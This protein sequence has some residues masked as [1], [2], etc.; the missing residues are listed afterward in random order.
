M[1]EKQPM[2]Q[3]MEGDEGAEVN[4]GCYVDFKKRIPKSLKIDKGLI[5]VKFSFFFTYAALGSYMPYLI[6]FLISIGLSATQAGFIIGLKTIVSLITGLAWGVIVDKTGKIKMIHLIVF[7]CYIFVVFS[8]PW[9]GALVSNPIEETDAQLANNLHNSS[10]L[11]NTTSFLNTTTTTTTMMPVKVTKA[12]NAIDTVKVNNVNEIFYVMTAILCLVAVFESP[13]QGI[14]DSLTIYILR[15]HKKKAN[16]GMQRAFGG[17]GLASGNLFAGLI[18]DIYDDPDM[19]AYTGIFYVFLVVSL[20]FMGV[21]LYV[22]R[23]R[24]M[25]LR[26]DDEILEEKIKLDDV[27]NVDENIE[28]KK[29]PDIFKPVLKIFSR[30][31]NV[32]FFTT[33]CIIGFAHSINYAILF[34]YMADDFQASKSVMGLSIF[35]AC[36]S[37]LLIFPISSKIISF[38]KGP[39]IAVLVGLFSYSL[40]YCLYSFAQNIWI[41]ICLQSLH[42]FGFGLFWS[43]AVEHTKRLSTEYTLTTMFMILNV[44]HTPVGNLVGNMIGGYLYEQHGGRTFFLGISILLGSWAFL[45]LFYNIFFNKEDMDLKHPE[46]EMDD[47]KEE[48]EKLQNGESNM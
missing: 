21:I 32:L 43:A 35:I 11:M 14:L 34:L 6:V 47:C 19:S 48:L 20:S 3:E 27:E 16:Y 31:S 26:S 18:A 40:R 37:E 38:F 46:I 36:T 25:S 5:A 9:I 44:C 15:N 28:K 13:L 12:V 10:L 22:Y 8:L 23:G 41:I 29:Q 17:L 4:G 1:S 2:N 33:V 24:D 39:W 30:L 7:I 45:M 42:M